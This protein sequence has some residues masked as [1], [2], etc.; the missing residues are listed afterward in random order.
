MGNRAELKRQRR[1]HRTI[2]ANHRDLARV[3][4]DMADMTRMTAS[5]SSLL[6]PLLALMV[7]D[8]HRHN[9]ENIDS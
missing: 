1:W 3:E 9:R 4:Q 8:A 6:W 2:R 7:T 5:G